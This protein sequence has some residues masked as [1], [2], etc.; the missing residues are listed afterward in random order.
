M[1][2]HTRFLT[3]PEP[4]GNVSATLIAKEI[5]MSTDITNNL[6]RVVADHCFCWLASCDWPDFLRPNRRWVSE[7]SA[8]QKQSAY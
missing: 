6:P 2:P 4:D 1:A 3:V 8:Q 5:A 7:R